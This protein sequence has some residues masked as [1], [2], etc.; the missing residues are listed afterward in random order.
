[1]IPRKPVRHLQGTGWQVLDDAPAEW[2][3]CESQ[4]DAELIS[5]YGPLCCNVFDGIA[6]GPDVTMRLEAMA[7]AVVRNIGHG[8]A[9]RFIRQ[10]LK[11]ARA[12]ERG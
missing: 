6:A 9:E 12:A 4:E 7:D 3:T 8:V 1:M 5:Q 2:I 11:R 10:A